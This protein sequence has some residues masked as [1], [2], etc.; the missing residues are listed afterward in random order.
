[1]NK[2]KT[3]KSDDEQKNLAPKFSSIKKENPFKVPD[4]YFDSLSDKINSKIPGLS[5]KKIDESVKRSIFKSQ[6]VYVLAAASITIFIGIFILLNKNGST[7]EFLSGITLEQILDEKPEIIESMD[8]SLLVEFYMASN[9]NDFG[10]VFENDFEHDSSFTTDEIILYLSTE[11][12]GLNFLN[13]LPI[14]GPYE[15]CISLEEVNG[16]AWA[17]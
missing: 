15:S 3:Y 11:E 1:M 2:R 17:L 12:I 10:N 4:D 5:G 6:F 14:P 8:E 13:Y 9:E 16:K 7:D